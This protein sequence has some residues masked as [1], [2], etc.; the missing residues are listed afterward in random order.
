MAY[1]NRRRP[2]LARVVA[3]QRR[4]G[5]TDSPAQQ[6]QKRRDRE[7]LNEIKVQGSTGNSNPMG[8]S[9]KELES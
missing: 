9:G 5:I 2:T 7:R 1:N 4:A 3:A 8:K 6:E